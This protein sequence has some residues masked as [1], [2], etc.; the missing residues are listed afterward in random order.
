MIID[1][2]THSFPAPVVPNAMGEL[3]RRFGDFVPT[4]DGSEDG[5]RQMIHTLAIDYCVVLNI[6]T[7]PRQQ[8]NVNNFA[9]ASNH[10]QIISFGSVHPCAA[11]AADELDR[12]K[13]LGLKGIKLHSDYQNFWVDDERFFPLYRKIGELG[14]ITVFHCGQDMGCF[15]PIRCT[16]ERLARVLPLFGDTP[17]VAAH[18]GG[19]CMWHDVEKHLVGKNVY[20]DTAYTYGNMPPEHTH[21]IV[22]AHGADRILLGSDMPWSK[23]TDE[24][25]FVRSWGLSDADT[26]KVLGENAARL[27]GLPLSGGASS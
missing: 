4:Y 25:R 24:A 9:A 17:V 18:M 27:L 14:L 21:R 19:Y 2:H 7:N 5:L 3:Q 16:P 12:I 22:A 26:R 8:T 1:F 6:A 20:F 10:G 23:T 15:E 13:A 11:D